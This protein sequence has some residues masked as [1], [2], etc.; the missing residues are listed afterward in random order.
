M[1]AEGEGC[2]AGLRVDVHGIKE[3]RIVAP[4]ARQI[5]CLNLGQIMPAIR[6]RAISWA[7]HPLVWFS[8][9]KKARR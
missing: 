6:N 9:R 7:A 2:R 5:L 4:S 3:P 1:P 8:C